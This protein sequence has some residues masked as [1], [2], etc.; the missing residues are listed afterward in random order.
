MADDDVEARAEAMGD[1]ERSSAETLDLQAPGQLFLQAEPEAARS[2]PAVGVLLSPLS[3]SVVTKTV[4]RSWR[5]SMTSIEGR[6]RRAERRREAV[7]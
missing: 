5:P 2:E 7:A 4:D 1:P 6:P 3:P